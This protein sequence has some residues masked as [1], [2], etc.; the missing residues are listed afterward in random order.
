MGRITPG[1]VAG[2]LVGYL[3][4]LEFTDDERAT[5]EASREILER[6]QEEWGR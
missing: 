3:E 4:I 1:Y 2:L 6:K 5:L